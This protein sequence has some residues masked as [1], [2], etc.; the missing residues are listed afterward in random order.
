MPDDVCICA[1]SWI[2][3]GWKRW[4]LCNRGGIAQNLAKRLTS[5]R[6]EL[7]RLSDQYSSHLKP[8]F[9][10][11]KSTHRHGWTHM[12]THT[13]ARSPSKSSL[14]LAMVLHDRLQ[15]A[16][17]N[18][19]TKPN[20]THFQGHTQDGAYLPG[21]VSVLHFPKELPLKAHRRKAE[22][23]ILDISGTEQVSYNNSYYLLSLL[24]R[25]GQMFTTVLLVIN[26]AF[27][28]LC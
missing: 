9:C 10:W 2:S 14:T 25:S 18:T 19:H 4:L 11:E 12:H 7:M 6:T 23:I 24:N 17:M 3:A 5:L 22:P 28:S 16:L 26:T 8:S 21:P 27:S 1:R 13:L 15:A 20:Q